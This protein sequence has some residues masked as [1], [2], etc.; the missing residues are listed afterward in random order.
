LY[1]HHSGAYFLLVRSVIFFVLVHVVNIEKFQHL[2]FIVNGRFGQ[3]DFLSDQNRWCKA[4][5][6]L[7]CFVVSIA[8]LVILFAK[9]E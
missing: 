5:I 4:G 9:S 1:K 3:V 2:N 7:I 6:D 8:R